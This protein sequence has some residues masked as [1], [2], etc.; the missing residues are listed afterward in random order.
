MSNDEILRQPLVRIARLPVIGDVVTPLYLGSRWLLRQ[1]MAAAAI[2][3]GHML[4]QRFGGDRGLGLNQ[5]QLDHGQ[6]QPGAFWASWLNR[7]WSANLRWDPR[8]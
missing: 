7:I 1:R 5:R 6:V 3:A 8:L 2:E 4:G